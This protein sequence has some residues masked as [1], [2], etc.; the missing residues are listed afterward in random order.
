MKLK[1]FLPLAGMLL[2]SLAGASVANAADLGGDCCAD[3]EER[4]A[5]LEATTA[6]KG[7]RKVSLTVTGMVAEQLTYWDDGQESNLYVS[8][9][10]ATLGSNVQFNGKAQISPGFTAGYQ[11]YL[12]LNYS[13]PEFFNQD[14]DNGLASSPNLSTGVSVYRSYWYLKSDTLGQ[15]SLGKLSQAS[16]KAAAL[17]DGSGSLLQANWVLFDGLLFNIRENGT[18]GPNIGVW[19]NLG[20]CQ[21]ISTP[22]GANCN[23]LTTNAIKY[24]SPTFGGFN[25][26]ASW[27]ED[28]FWDVTARYA[29][30]AGGFKLATAVS[31][32]ENKDE[33]AGLYDLFGS[34]DHKDVS[35]FQAGL[36]LEHVATGLFA[37]GAYGEEDVNGAVT[38]FGP[39]GPTTPLASSGF[40]I[41]DG[42][43]FYVKG[44][45]KAKL[46]SLGQ[47]VFYGEYAQN[48]DQL[49]PNLLGAGYTG[50]E[51]NRY[52]AGVVQYVDAASMS[53]W[54]KYRHFEGELDDGVTTTKL[55]PID[56]L[57]FGSAINF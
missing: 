53:L 30:E 11:L 34:P 1:P 44:G 41:P 10:G 40:A 4:I 46:T 23:G 48:N 27:G 28:D 13:D 35:Y 18:A 47:T 36:Y 7:N 2:T 14:T 57:V 56:F 32:S 20:H 29:G 50:S 45:V 21:L 31:Y 9:L 51:L 25:V 22:I 54:L 24:D 49:G 43:H 6:R 33:N 26:S 12:E 5:E 55:E 15:V 19:G 16:D 52:G 3:L 39:N 42:N 37:Y 8:G 38:G 17:V